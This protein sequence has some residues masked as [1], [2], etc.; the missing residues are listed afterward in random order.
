MTTLPALLQPGLPSAKGP[1]SAALIERL[2]DR[3]PQ[4]HLEP[5]WVPLRDA[6]P[7]GLD[8]QLA[9]YICYELHYR[10][11]AGVDQDWEWNAGL[12]HLRS[13]F[14]RIFLAAVRREVGQIDADDTAEREMARLSVEPADGTGPSYHLRDEG[15]W[16][17][18]REYF[19]HRSLY[20][21]KEGD[22]HAWLIPRLG[23]QAKAS[24]VA[25]EYDEYGAGSA[26]RLHQNLFADLL[27]EAD[28]DDRYLGYLD[29]VPAESLALVNL[30]SM[31]G[32]HRRLRGAAAGHFAATEITSSPGSQRMV[33]ALERL[34]APEAC[35]RFYR[36]HVEADAV[37]EQVVRHDVVGNLVS[38]EPELDTDVVFGIRAFDALEDRLAAHLMESWQAGRSSLPRP[39]A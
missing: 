8:V 17:Q 28:L 24:F 1:I 29:A 12:L 23:G 6:E 2:G 31:F 10:G 30:M 16:E 27:R 33:A 3:A 22:P 32:L 18:M 9:L 14:E 15:T 7:L 4:N 39:L 25:I 34:G 5:V 20:H 37:H 21:L 38:R 35:V 36:E 26:S 19:V 13:Q 11:F